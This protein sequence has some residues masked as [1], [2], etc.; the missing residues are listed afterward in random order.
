[1]NIIQERYYPYYI[2]SNTS[3][4]NNVN[5]DDYIYDNLLSIKN[6]FTKLLDWICSEAIRREW[7]ETCQRIMEIKKEMG[8]DKV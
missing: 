5:T 7:Y 2:V 3:N 8:Y 4:F 1:M 6:D